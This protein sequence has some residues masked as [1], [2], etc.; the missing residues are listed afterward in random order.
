MFDNPILEG[1][2]ARPPCG[3]AA[4]SILPVI[5]FLLVRAVGHEDLA[6]DP[7]PGSSPRRARVWSLAE[8]LLHRFMFH[9][10]PD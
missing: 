8:Y 5:G 10:E 2:V 6:S 1:A 3:A 7:W 4:A 9:L